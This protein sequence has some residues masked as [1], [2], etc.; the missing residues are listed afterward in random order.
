MMRPVLVESGLAVLMTTRSMELIEATMA[1][2]SLDIALI[3][4]D[5]GY[6][7]TMTFDGFGKDGGDKAVPKAYTMAAKYWARI[8]F[9]ID[10]QDDAEKDEKPA[11]Q[12]SPPRPAVVPTEQSTTTAPIATATNDLPASPSPFFDRINADR[13]Q[14][15]Q[16]IYERPVIILEVL[17]GEGKR[18]DFRWEHL[19]D[20]DTR[21][22]AYRVAMAHVRTS[23]KQLA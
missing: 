18:P 4:T 10:L 22:W 21:A 2:V 8:A 19:K 5:T 23:E 16:A 13:K 20:A 1:H 9:M 17:Q 15:N 3:D 12:A 11:R 14:R 7:E 6:S